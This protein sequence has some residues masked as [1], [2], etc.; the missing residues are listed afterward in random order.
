MTCIAGITERGR[1][2]LGGDSA[3]TMGS[4]EQ[5]CTR[6]PKVWRAGD[7]LVGAGGTTGFCD[8]MREVKVPR[9]TRTA[10]LDHWLRAVPAAGREW[11]KRG[12]PDR[13]PK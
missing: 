1:T 3:V 8:M 12:P 6:Q 9:M 7:W 10:S 13:P 2:W 5:W 11:R 4:D